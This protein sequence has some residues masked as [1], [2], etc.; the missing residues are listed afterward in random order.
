MK[1]YSILF[2]VT[3]AALVTGCS[4][5]AGYTAGKDAPLPPNR[6]YAIVEKTAET[7]VF[8]PEMLALNEIEAPVAAQPVAPAA[9]AVKLIQQQFTQVLAENQETLNQKPYRWIQKM[10]WD[11]RLEKLA[12]R[13]EN[14]GL[15]AKIQQKIMGK[16]M[17]KAAEQFGMPGGDTGNILAIVS[18]STGIASWVL[19]YIGFACAITAIVT[20]ALA[21]KRDGRRAFALTGI[22]LGSIGLVFSLLLIFLI[23]GVF[24]L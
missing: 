11:S 8:T 9:E 6:T 13:Y 14:P 7:P 2:L 23:A 3:A 4:R 20:G 22:I 16:T 12:A 10:D 17:L 18:L 5:Y 15:M 19:P 1:N 21:L 24:L